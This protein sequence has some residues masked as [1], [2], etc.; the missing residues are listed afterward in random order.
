MKT[1]LLTLCLLSG[2]TFAAADSVRILTPGSIRTLL[3]DYP[4][5]GTEASHRDYDVLLHI[6]NTRTPEECAEAAL[7]E[8]VSLE[9]MFAGE[10][11]PLTKAE[12][13]RVTPRL[14]GGF[15]EIGANIYIAKKIFKRP[16]P[17]FV[18]R[19]L[20]PCIK[21]EGSYA[22]PSGHAATSRYFARKLMEIFPDRKEAILKRSDEVAWNRVLGGV[23][24]PSDIE[25]GK[26]LGD[27]LAR[28]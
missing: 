17:Y 3:G 14:L 9:R 15:A 21:K 28:D 18:D 7:E 11:G 13:K 20:T 23:H 5:L 10:N 12:I 16:R 2:S 8:K 22:Y 19:H 27:E 4:A 24:H 1:L 25:A 26:K 6:Q